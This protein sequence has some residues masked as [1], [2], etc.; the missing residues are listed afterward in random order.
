MRRKGK[1]GSLRY[2]V[3]C[4]SPTTDSIAGHLLQ[5]IVSGFW[6]VVLVVLQVE[7]GGLV[8]VDSIA[9]VLVAPSFL[10]SVDR[11]KWGSLFVCCLFWEGVFLGCL[12]S[13]QHKTCHFHPTNRPVHQRSNQ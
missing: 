7:G 5:A 3:S 9:A 2:S 13:Q 1:E 6:F 10:P 8:G 11:D 4:K 12:T